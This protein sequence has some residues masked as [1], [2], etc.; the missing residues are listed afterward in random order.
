MELKLT[1]REQRTRELSSELTEKIRNCK[2]S[3]VDPYEHPRVRAIL[4]LLA[5]D[6]PKAVRS[7]QDRQERIEVELVGVVERWQQPSDAL[8]AVFTMIK[9]ISENGPST[10]AKVTQDAGAQRLLS[11]YAEIDEQI[12]EILSKED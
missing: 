9:E 5:D 1:K 4:K 8:A 10:V 7:L 3:G 6:V 12:V 2:T 11:E